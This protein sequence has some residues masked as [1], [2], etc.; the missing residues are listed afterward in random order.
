[1]LRFFFWTLLLINALLLAYNLGYLGNWAFEVHEPQRMKM[2]QDADRLQ[3]LSAKAAIALNEPVVEKK[4]ESIACL[5]VGNF[6]QAEV[7][8]FEDKL[9]PM[10]LG[11]RQTKSTIAEVAT[12]MV[13]IP[14]LG[15]KDNAEKKAA[16]LRRIGITEFFIV[17]DQSD[18]RWGISL[19]VFK[20][21]EA[22]KAHLANLNNK[23]VRTARIG[24]R[25]VSAKKFVYQL[26]ALTPDEKKSVDLIKEG[27]AAQ[28]T[29][30][31][32]PQASNRK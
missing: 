23:G 28:E 12:N 18:M 4:D 6:S 14:S 27:F 31:C 29:R 19:G 11:E 26:L 16:E 7:S 21:E 2:E 5:E 10:S 9:K 3:L 30:E 1:M 25:T 32:P 20:T 15:N 17:Q 13:F 22:A 24:P 8:N